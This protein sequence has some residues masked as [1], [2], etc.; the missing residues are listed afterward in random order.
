MTYVNANLK[1]FMLVFLTPLSLHSPLSLSLSHTFPHYVGFAT[2]ILAHNF[3]FTNLTFFTFS[4][5]FIQWLRFK[6]TFCNFKSQPLTPITS[7]IIT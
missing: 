3:F 1:N 6:V 4:Y 2:T 5:F 7:G